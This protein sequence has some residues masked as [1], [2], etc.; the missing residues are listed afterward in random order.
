MLIVQ[1]RDLDGLPKVGVVSEN[2][3]KLN[4]VRGSENLYQLSMSAIENGIR[5]TEH[6]EG[7][8]FES[9]ENYDE[10][11]GNGRLLLPLDHPDPARTTISGTGLT[12]LGSAS[13]RDAMHRK[14]ASDIESVTDSMRIFRMGIEGGR[15]E[16]GEIGFQPE[17]FYK[18]NTTMA[19]GCG[20][21]LSMPGFAFDGGEE[22][23]LV[24][25]YII[26]PDQKPWR[27]GF[28]LSN[29]FSDHVMEKQN[30]LN[31]S[32]S[33][34]RSC[35]Y[36]PEVFVGEPLPSDIRGYVMIEREGREVWKKEFLTGEAN[37]SH[38]IANLEH[39]HFKYDQFR[40]VGDVHIHF[41][42]TSTLSF[43]DGFVTQDGDI[44]E[45]WAPPFVRPLRNP[46]RMEKSNPLITVAQL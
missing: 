29:E 2:G 24:G 31:L 37:M 9:F 25:L 27:I 40:V 38:S 44:F 21:E 42:G 15:P 4:I 39:H 13:G 46:L 19:V 11:A 45:I 26:G 36:G 10:V 23:E 28:A 35:S 3:K 14:E 17:W 22:P 34:L 5:L 8:G 16:E 7:M 32:H 30:Y 6:I 33:K 41:F 43:S 18:G 20:Q 1:I 12:H